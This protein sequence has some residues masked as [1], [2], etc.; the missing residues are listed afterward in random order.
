MHFPALANLSSI[1][2]ISTAYINRITF[3][4]DSYI[5]S[6]IYFAQTT[7][8]TT[9]LV[10]QLYCYIK[11]APL[12]KDQVRQYLIVNSYVFQLYILYFSYVFCSNQPAIPYSYSQLHSQLAGQ[13]YVVPPELPPSQLGTSLLCFYFY[14]LCFAAVLLKFTYYAQE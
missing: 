3:F 14:P 2:N 7:Q 10:S 9:Q 13:L 1:S 11:A 8:L 12:N 5:A 4:T 6:Y